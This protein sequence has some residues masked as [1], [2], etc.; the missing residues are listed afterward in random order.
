LLF[1]VLTRTISVAFHFSSWF[2]QM[3]TSFIFN[4]DW[5]FSFLY[6]RAI[7]L[8]FPYSNPSASGASSPPTVRI[9]IPDKND[10]EN[11][12]VSKKNHLSRD[13]RIYNK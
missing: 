8:P 6:F 13:S 4:F 1:T 3:L 10:R 7:K 12:G 2:G 5:L 9:F 11:I